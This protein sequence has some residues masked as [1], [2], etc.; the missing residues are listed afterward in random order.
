MYVDLTVVPV[1]APDDAPV[2]RVFG[3]RVLAVIGKTEGNGGV[4]DF[5]RALATRAWTEGLSEPAL[6]VMSGV[7]LLCRRHTAGRSAGLST[8]HTVGTEPL[9]KYGAEAQTPCS[10]GVT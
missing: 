5:S 9:W 10:G 8:S 4:N 1:A 7:V 3:R 2:D 6:T